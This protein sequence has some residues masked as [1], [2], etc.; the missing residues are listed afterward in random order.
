MV[1]TGKDESLVK[2]PVTE[3]VCVMKLMYILI[4]FFLFIWSRVSL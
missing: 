1:I 2:T 3:I 4:T